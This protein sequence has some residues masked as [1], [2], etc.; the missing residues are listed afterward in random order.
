MV[1]IN[2]YIV[3]FNTFTAKKP[4]DGPLGEKMLDQTVTVQARMERYATFWAIVQI[5]QR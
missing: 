5:F 2:L 4:A 3:G 1:G